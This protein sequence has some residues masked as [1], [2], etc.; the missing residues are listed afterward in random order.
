MG[1]I[2][3]VKG[4]RIR[5]SMMPLKGRETWA[6]YQENLGSKIPGAGNGLP[7]DKAGV[8]LAGHSHMDS[9]H[10]CMT[11]NKPMVWAR[12]LK[13][14]CHHLCG[15]LRLSLSKQNIPWACTMGTPTPP[16]LLIPFLFC[17]KS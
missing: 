7:G 4:G 1:F 2:R 17:S 12:G 9:D 3:E 15:R 10:L 14:L 13:G 5:Y 16:L 11:G 8:P 6:E